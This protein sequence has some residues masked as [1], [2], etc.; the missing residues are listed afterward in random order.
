[1]AVI[2]LCLRALWPGPMAGSAPPS[3]LATLFT[4][5]ALCLAQAK[6]DKAALPRDQAPSQPEKHAD[7][8]GLG[9]CVLHVA[10]GFIFTRVFDITPITFVRRVVLQ[11]ELARLALSWR[12]IGPHQ[13]R[14]P[15]EAI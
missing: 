14:A 7:H 1:M 10:A 8:N 6:D 2:A 3:D 9:C 12:L 11:Q 4:E 15:P 13:A 5:H